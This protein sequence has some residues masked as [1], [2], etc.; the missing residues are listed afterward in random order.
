MREEEEE[1]K[2][3]GGGGGRAPLRRQEI[4]APPAMRTFHPC[5]RAKCAHDTPQFRVSLALPL[6]L[7]F[8]SSP[9]PPHPLPSRCGPWGAGQGSWGHRALIVRPVGSGVGQR[10]RGNIDREM[11]WLQD[12][13]L[14]DC[15][16][17]AWGQGRLDR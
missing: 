10:P 11:R 6:G 8:V 2:E 4:R 12:P 16:N 17:A 7:D 5:L 15:R 1:E 9:L 14:R 13:S 3:E